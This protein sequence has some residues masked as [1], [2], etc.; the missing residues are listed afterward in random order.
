MNDSAT[1]ALAA[2]T[3]LLS[4]LLVAAIFGRIHRQ[5][6]ASV[7]PLGDR[8]ISGLLAL[9]LVSCW[10]MLVFPAASIWWV[11]AAPVP[12]AFYLVLLAGTDPERGFRVVRERFTQILLAGVGGYYLAL[13]VVALLTAP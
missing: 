7:E 4:L 9:P 8:V 11:L 13:A 2:V 6:G 10:V 1:G 12:L 5:E 3:V